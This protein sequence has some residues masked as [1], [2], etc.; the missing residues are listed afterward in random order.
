MTDPWMKQHKIQLQVL[1]VEILECASI[2]GAFADELPE[3][4]VQALVKTKTIVELPEF[5]TIDGLAFP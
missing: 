2:Q 5:L 4:E 3:I 1:T